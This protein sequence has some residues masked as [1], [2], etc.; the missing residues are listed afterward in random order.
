MVAQIAA[1]RALNRVRDVGVDTDKRTLNGRLG[2][3]VAR[4]RNE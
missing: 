4:T 3:S 1:W 2:A